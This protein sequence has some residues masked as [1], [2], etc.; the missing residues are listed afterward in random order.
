METVRLEEVSNALGCGIPKKTIPRLVC[1]IKSFW[2]TPR[3][4]NMSPEN[5]WLEDVFPTEIGRPDG[6]NP[7]VSKPSPKGPR[8]VVEGIC[9]GRNITQLYGNYNINHC[10]DPY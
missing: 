8:K 1:W 4:T 3:K 7:C 6:K 5:Q 2:A 9:W 10:K